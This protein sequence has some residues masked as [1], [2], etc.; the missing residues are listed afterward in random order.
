LNID[1]AKPKSVSMW[2]NITAFTDDGLFDAGNK[3][4]GQ[5]WSLRTLN[6]ANVFRAQHWGG[7]HDYDFTLNGTS[8]QVQAANGNWVHYALVY[9]G[10]TSSTYADGV[11]VGSK[12][13]TRNI[14]D[15]L[16]F[17]WGRYNG[18]GGQLTSIIDDASIWDHALTA[19]EVTCSTMACL[20]WRFPSLRRS[21]SLVSVPPLSVWWRVAG[22]CDYSR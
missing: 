6:S 16:N 5:N 15:T 4:P 22:P 9:D 20:R 12:A 8:G 11:L 13:S 19:T 14:T 2:A 17:E 1:G 10:T 7:A 21:F 3:Q 18:A